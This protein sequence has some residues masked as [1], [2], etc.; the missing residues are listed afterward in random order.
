MGI[1]T[2][3]SPL[4]RG[5]T[6]NGSYGSIVKFESSENITGDSFII[7]SE[8]KLHSSDLTI[9]TLLRVYRSKDLQQLSRFIIQFG[10]VVIK[11]LL[12]ISVNM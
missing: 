12:I 5:L 7:P 6:F 1:E 10:Y 4:L 2:K 11:L 9:N 8:I 3:I